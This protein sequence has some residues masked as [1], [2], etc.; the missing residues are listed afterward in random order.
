MDIK[1]DQPHEKNRLLILSLLQEE[2]QPPLLACG[3]DSRAGMQVGELHSGEREGSWCALIGGCGPG[4]L[5]AGQRGT[6]LLCDWLGAYPAFSDWWK[7]E[8][9][10]KTGEATSY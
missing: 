4:K 6:G 5:E 9:G 2:R 10:V 1:K 3:R 7:V 8:A